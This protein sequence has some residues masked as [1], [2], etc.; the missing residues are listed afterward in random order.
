MPK[1][2]GVS[3]FSRA[4]SM[5]IDEKETEVTTL[6]VTVEE[7]MTGNNGRSRY[8]CSYTVERGQQNHTTYG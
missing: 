1:P 7:S 8:T 3:D 5:D 2:V 6:S 4:H